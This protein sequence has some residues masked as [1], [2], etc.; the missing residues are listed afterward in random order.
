M[1]PSA[2]TRKGVAARSLPTCPT[3]APRGALGTEKAR[4]VSFQSR[5]APCGPTFGLSLKL[6]VPVAVICNLSPVSTS[7]PVS[8][9]L[10]SPE[11][12]T[13]LVVGDL[14]L[15]ALCQADRVPARH[16]IKHK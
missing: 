8:T 12:V 14:V 4:K 9:H 2:P 13:S 7:M 15:E 16:R 5:A 6:T 11:T 10:S 1:V 3:K